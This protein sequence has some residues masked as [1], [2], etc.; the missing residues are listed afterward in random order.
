[1]L[2]DTQ[3]ALLAAGVLL[4]ANFIA[5]ILHFLYRPLSDSQLREAI[6]DVIYFLDE[7]ADGMDNT[8]KRADAIRQFNDVG[9]GAV[10]WYQPS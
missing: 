3:V 8:Q 5:V 2:T 6:R 10:S 4:A 9:V 7:F 1:M